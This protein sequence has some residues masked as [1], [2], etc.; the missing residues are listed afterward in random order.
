MWEWYHSSCPSQKKIC[1][2]KCQSVQLSV[3]CI[4]CP[5]SYRSRGKRDWS[6]S[7]DWSVWWVLTSVRGWAE[8][9]HLALFPL[10]PDLAWS[11]S[12][13]VSSPSLFFLSSP[14]SPHLFI[15]LVVF[16]PCA[17]LFYSFSSSSLVSSSQPLLPCG[18]SFLR[19]PPIAPWSPP[20]TD[21]SSPPWLRC[22]LLLLL[23]VLGTRDCWAEL[24]LTWLH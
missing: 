18:L 12:F 16:L 22:F 6:S 19:T 21:L 5:A 24:Q 10:L 8:H 3:C 4:S 13:S 17:F 2:L 23:L 15:L 9:T 20:L 7:S 11:A 14:V 1:F